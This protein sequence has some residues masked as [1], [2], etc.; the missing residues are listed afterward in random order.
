MLPQEPSTSSRNRT[1]LRRVAA[2]TVV[3]VALLWA[4]WDSWG[5][6]SSAFV[7]IVVGTLLLVIVTAA[8]GAAAGSLIGLV[9]RRRE[10]RDAAL[11]EAA[12]AEAPDAQ[13]DEP[14]G[15]R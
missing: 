8:L 2:G 10:A 9:R 3:V 7:R 4:I 6:G 5:L 15:H 1:L 11:R 13:G 12:P 14:P